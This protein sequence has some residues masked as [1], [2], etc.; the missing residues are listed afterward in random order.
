[1]SRGVTDCHWL[2]ITLSQYH[3]CDIKYCRS[4]ATSLWTFALSNDQTNYNSY[5]LAMN[6]HG[7]YF[8]IYNVVKII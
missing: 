4:Q 1:M 2:V 6:M 5:I 8:Y 7:L 3:Y